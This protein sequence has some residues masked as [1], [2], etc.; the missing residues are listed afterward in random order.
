MSLEFT[1]EGSYTNDGSLETLGITGVSRVFVAS[2]HIKVLGS[3][4][5]AVDVPLV[6]RDL[7]GP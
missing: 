7:V 6:W 1:S 3:G 5:R 2:L 4:S